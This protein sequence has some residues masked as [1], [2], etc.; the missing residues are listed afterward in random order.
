[1]PKKKEKCGVNTHTNTKK[2]EY[3]KENLKNVFTHKKEVNTW[4]KLLPFFFFVALI[5]PPPCLIR[6][7]FPDEDL[8][9][10]HISLT[11]S[12]ILVDSR[13]TLLFERGHWPSG[14]QQPHFALLFLR[15]TTPTC[16]LRHRLFLAVL[17]RLF[18]LHSSIKDSLPDHPIY[19]LDDEPASLFMFGGSASVQWF[20]IMSG[21]VACF[22]VRFSG[23][24]HC[25]VD[26]PHTVLFALPTYMS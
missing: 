24:L 22:I 18:R 21:S 20:A 4:A 26:H 11:W 5:L 15:L 19:V 8:A 13:G 6:F 16:T 2:N 12:I 10:P 1:M 25:Q 17:A 7:A 3:L 14:S 23:L 9:C